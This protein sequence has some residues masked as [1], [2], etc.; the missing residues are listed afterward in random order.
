MSGNDASSFG[1]LSSNGI[2][3]AALSITGKHLREKLGPL[4]NQSKLLQDQLSS[5]TP[6]A[7]TSIVQTTFTTLDFASRLQAKKILHK[8]YSE[9][10]TTIRTLMMDLFPPLRAVHALVGE[11][12]IEM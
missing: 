10:V 1:S 6:V 3:L 2:K 4:D 12:I 8:Q 5:L 9:V 7:G 11:H